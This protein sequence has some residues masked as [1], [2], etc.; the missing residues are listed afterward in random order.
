MSTVLTELFRT[1]VYKRTQGRV[2][3][4]VTFA[5]LAL[6]ALMGC[7]RLSQQL[8]FGN[9]PYIRFGLPGLLFLLALWLCYRIVNIPRFAD[10]LIS[11]EAEMAKVSWPTRK[12]LFRSSVV[13]LVTILLLTAVLFVFDLAWRFLLIDLL[14]ITGSG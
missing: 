2:T 1:Q 4:R 6:G 8:Q 13:V 10:F 12:E 14:K 11:V 9:D 7:Y 3:R 5:A